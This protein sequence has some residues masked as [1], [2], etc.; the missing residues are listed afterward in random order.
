M[1]SCYR[2]MWLSMFS[3]EISPGEELSEEA[4]SM[5]LKLRGLCGPSRDSRPRLCCWHS[6]CAPLGDGFLT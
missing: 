5:A 2:D 3:E 1:S 4:C 6:V